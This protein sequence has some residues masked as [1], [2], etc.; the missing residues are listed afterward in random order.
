MLTVAQ[1][2][3]AL[4]SP[5]GRVRGLVRV[6]PV[7]G[8][9][10]VPRF[11]MPGHGLVDF[12]VTLGGRHH[13]LRCPLMRG[14][15]AARRLRVLAEKDRGLGGRFFTEWRLLEGEIVLFDG[16]GAAFEVDVLLRPTPVGEEIMAFVER[17]AV[18]GDVEAVEAVRRS[19]EELCV[20][21][22]RVG[23]SG[24]AMHRVSVGTG[25]TVVLTGFSATDERER[26]AELLGRAVSG[27]DVGFGASGAV[28]GVASGY[29]EYVRDDR[30]GVATVMTEGRW[31]LIDGDGRMLTSDR[32]DW[33]GECSEGLVLGQKGDKCGFLDTSGSEAIPF[34]YDDASSFSEGVALVSR[35]G[36]SF[37][38]DPRGE[39]IKS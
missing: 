12:E 28:S 19:F 6:A 1:Y 23:R 38:I 32:Y 15:A 29:E 10:G 34:V 18:E 5:D 31:G 4:S 16:D 14:E 30:W 39:V 27:A 9:D 8:P 20:W 7:Y 2:I 36:E 3:E 25:G 21:A 11:V 22:D 35:D 17:M 37:F 24:I 26:V 13:T 33:L